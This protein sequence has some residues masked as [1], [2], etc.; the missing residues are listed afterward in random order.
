MTTTENNILKH[1]DIQ[2]IKEMKKII[3]FQGIEL[4]K[5]YTETPSYFRK[6]KGYWRKIKIHDSLRRVGFTKRTYYQI[7]NTQRS[8][9]NFDALF[10]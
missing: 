6:F 9:E 10:N 4:M 1:S 5:I 7:K 8:P 3:N 2:K